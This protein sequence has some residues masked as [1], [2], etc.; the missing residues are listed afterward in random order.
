MEVKDYC[1]G[2][3][4]IICSC[5]G[6]AEEEIINWLL[7]EERLLFTREQ[8]VEKKITRIRPAKGIEKKF[9][10]LDYGNKSVVIFRIIDSSNEQFK[11]SN[12]Y[13]DRYD[14]CDYITKSRNRNIND[15]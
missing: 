4:Y 7:D 14:V 8:L 9:L 10:S 11:L 5:E 1:N 15:Y 2:D 13:K 12:L 3:Y 6:T